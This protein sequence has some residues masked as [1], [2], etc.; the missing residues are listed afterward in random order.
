LSETTTISSAQ[1]IR[2]ELNRLRLARQSLSASSTALDQQRHY[3][4]YLLEVKPDHLCIDFF[5]PSTGNDVFIAGEELLL[6]AK[7]S[8]TRYH[9]F[10][11]Y[12][13][14]GDDHTNLY[15]RL[16]MPTSLFRTEHRSD[17]RLHLRRDIAPN[18]MIS[19]GTGNTQPA[20]LDNISLSGAGIRLPDEEKPQQGDPLKCHF[21]FNSEPLKLNAEIRHLRPV[22]TSKEVHVGV[23]FEPLPR[24]TRRELHQALMRLQ[25]H[26]IRTSVNL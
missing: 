12:L 11:E 20:K 2:R 25:R 14:H 5:I 3:S 17:Y 4:T 6:E 7:Y 18:L 21:H 8:G 19:S 15:H 16:S 26:T 22:R 23:A 1:S 10:C 13:D 24:E 9:F